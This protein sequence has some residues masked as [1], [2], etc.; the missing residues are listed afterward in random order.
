MSFRSKIENWLKFKMAEAAIF[1]LENNIGNVLPAIENLQKEVLY[2]PLCHLDKKLKIGRN[3]NGHI[4]R[5][6]GY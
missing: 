6:Q 1:I 5:T 2:D 4:G 3:S